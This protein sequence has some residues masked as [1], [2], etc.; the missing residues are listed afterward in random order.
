MKIDG[1]NADS[2]S[3]KATDKD[4]MQHWMFWKASKMPFLEKG[5]VDTISFQ[6]K[7][8]GAEKKK[9][10]KKDDQL[11]KNMHIQT[12]W[13]Q[14]SF[15][16]GVSA[17]FSSHLLIPKPIHGRVEVSETLQ[18]VKCDQI[19]Q[20]WN[21]VNEFCVFACYFFRSGVPVFKSPSLKWAHH[22]TN[23]VWQRAGS[24]CSYEAQNLMS[25]N[26]EY[27]STCWWL[28]RLPVIRSMKALF[29]REHSLSC[30]MM[31]P[32]HRQILPN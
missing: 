11:T 26:N 8:W 16:G 21:S 18:F 3:E 10:K 13:L 19:K 20:K 29:S 9:K 28:S 27:H 12:D 32:H 17:Q 2:V 25:M 15:H 4:V 1:R 14:I 6:N 7:W 5:F 24:L 22:K 31:D 30:C 23:T